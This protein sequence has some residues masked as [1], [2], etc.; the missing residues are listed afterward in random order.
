[1]RSGASPPVA[2]RFSAP[3]LLHAEPA[4]GALVGERGVDEAVEQHPASRREQRL[5]P[6]GHEL[7]PGGRV[8]QRLGARVDIDGRVDD[9]LADALGQL[10]AAGLAQHGH[11]LPALAQR[12][13][14]RRARASSCRRRRVPRR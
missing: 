12:R 1:M 8:E 5:E 13:G 3:D 2:K 4:S 7:R 9:E 10:D 6:L 14:E 11:V